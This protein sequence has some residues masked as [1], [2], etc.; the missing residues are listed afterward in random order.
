MEPEAQQRIERVV[1]SLAIAR[2]YIQFYPPGSSN[3]TDVLEHLVNSIQVLTKGYVSASNEEGEASLP[4]PDDPDRKPLAPDGLLFGVGRRSLH[5]GDQELVP[6][7]APAAKLAGDLYRLRVKSIHFLPGVDSSELQHFLEAACLTSEQVEA[8]KGIAKLLKAQGVERISVTLSRDLSLVDRQTLPD[9]VDLMAY[10]KSRKEARHQDAEGFGDAGPP[11]GDD[12]PDD[13][14]EDISDIQNFFAGIAQGS[15]KN[16]RFL[17]ETLTDPQKLAETLNHIHLVDAS[18]EKMDASAEDPGESEASINLLRNSLHAIT[19]V[20]ASLPIDRRGEIIETVGQAILTTDDTTRQV[21]IENAFAAQVGKGTIEDSVLSSLPD[22]DIAKTL[23]HNVRFHEGT[24]NTIS[25]FL[26]EFS[27][28]PRRRTAIQHMVVKTLGKDE[29]ARVREAVKILETAPQHTEAPLPAK[30]HDATVVEEKD[31]GGLMFS[32]RLDPGELDAI[33]ASLEHDFHKT[34]PLHA[35]RTLVEVFNHPVLAPVNQKTI[36]LVGTLLAESLESRE[37]DFIAEVL[38]EIVE[39]MSVDVQASLRPCAQSIIEAC[40]QGDHPDALIGELRRHESKSS[41]FKRLI[42]VLELM[43]GTAAELLFNRL[44]EEQNYSKR[45]FLVALFAELGDPQVPFLANKLHSRHWFIVRNVAFIL[46]KIGSPAAL[47]GLAR[48]IHHK[49]LRVRS[50]VLR[51]IAAIKGERAEQMLI[52]RLS[53][54]EAEVRRAAAEWLGVMG[55]KR[56]L[57]EFVRLISGRSAPV[58]KDLDYAPGVVRAIGMLGGPGEL[59]LLKAFMPKRRAFRGQKMKT[60]MDTCEESIARL[61][62]RPAPAR[63]TGKD[64]LRGTHVGR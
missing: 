11:A 58:M 43:G 3:V 5:Y 56:A 31:R 57:P 10:L 18:A 50:E 28:D 54:P 41:E 59:A 46:G 39:E 60:L 36:D 47:D 40:G 48:A 25:N 2:K 30:R 8:K 13:A 7:N 61:E 63:E 51:A 14:T 32:L 4:A 37:Y 16:R 22:E 44:E 24:A 29:E 6:E 21:M 33:E 45:L 34:T 55:A 64:F 19:D 26:D 12:L 49:D 23:S 62:G 52:H 42:F 20:I 17:L 9:N 38:Q 53:D 35:A 1:A 15:E 27:A